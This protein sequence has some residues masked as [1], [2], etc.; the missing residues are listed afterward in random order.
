MDNLFVLRGIINRANYLGKE[1]WLTL[2]DIEQCFDSLWLK[3]CIK[4]LWNLG[5]ILGLIYFILCLIYFM[6]KDHFYNE[7]P[8]EDTDTLFLS[9]FIKVIHFSTLPSSFSSFW[10]MP[11]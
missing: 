1:L 11:T 8:L 2:Y 9:N 6:N 3:D 7:T 10:E 4:S 5:V